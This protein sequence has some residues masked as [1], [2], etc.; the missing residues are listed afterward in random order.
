MSKPM[1]TTRSGRYL[2]IAFT[3]GALMLLAGCARPIRV[4]GNRPSRHAPPADEQITMLLPHKIDILP[5]TKPAS[6]DDDA[7]PDGIEVVLRPLDNVGD[8]TKA[9]GQFRFELYHY[10]RAS[11]DSRGES[12]GQWNIAVDTPAAQ[13]QHWD[14]ITRTYRFRLEW[15]GKQPQPG[16]YVLEVTYIAP[17]GQRLS[18]LYTLQATV[19][20]RRI[21]ETTDKKQKRWGIF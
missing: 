4:F 5:F 1:S 13:E 18:S 6:F 15:T 20:R 12:L 10:R 2:T 21:K 8:Q 3:A 7:I 17:W 11:S 9:I 16:K 14:R 19:P